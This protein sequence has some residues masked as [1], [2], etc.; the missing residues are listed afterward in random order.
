[1]EWGTATRDVQ[2]LP[3]CNTKTEKKPLAEKN[4]TANF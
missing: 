2:R 3:P 1:V 4:A